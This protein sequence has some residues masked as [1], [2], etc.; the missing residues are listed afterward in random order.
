MLSGPFTAP[1]RAQGPPDAVSYQTFYDALSPYGIWVDDPDYG[2]AWV[3]SA[4]PDFQ[5]YRTNGHWVYTDYG[6]TWVSDYQ[7]GWAPFHYGRWRYSDEFGWLWVPGYTWGPAWVA[8]RQSEGYYGWAPLGPPPVRRGVRESIG[9]SFSFGDAPVTA[10]RWCFVPAAYVASPVIA[11]YYV[12]PARTTVIYNNTTIIHNT[13]VNNNVV[14]NNGTTTNNTAVVN[15]ANRT[16]V[17]NV[18]Q[19]HPTSAH[20]GGG[21]PAYPAG[22]GRA[23]VEK[24][25]GQ[26]IKPLVVG[27]RSTPGAGLQGQ[28][29]ALYRPE[30]AA[31]SRPGRGPSAGLAPAPAPQ[32]TVPLPKAAALAR[33]AGNTNRGLM[34]DNAVHHLSSTDPDPIRE[35]RARQATARQAQASTPGVPNPVPSVEAPGKGKGPDQTTAHDHA[36]PASANSSSPGPVVPPVRSARPDGSNAAG[37]AIAPAAPAVKQSQPT[38]AGPYPAT[39]TDRTADKAA[40]AAKIDKVAGQ[41]KRAGGLPDTAPMPAKAPPANK[42]QAQPQRQAAAQ[43][44]PAVRPMSQLQPAPHP[45]PAGRPASQ[46]HPSAGPRPH[47]ATVRAA[48]HSDGKGPDRH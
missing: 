32:K 13:Y 20:D 8:W 33:S 47:P 3:P 42:P 29:L 18:G 19:G 9:F 1:T 4:G 45:H 37:S 30:V 21:Q 10:A 14:N 17:N 15:N 43:P 11:T 41:P 36:Q 34:P 12:P 27:N 44:A 7:W 6:W 31:P 22:P 25:T 16:E 5:P 24:A 35:A 40:K 2:Y 28:S 39:P 23:E 48:P 46:P 38:S 26:T